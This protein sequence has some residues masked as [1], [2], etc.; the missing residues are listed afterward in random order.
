MIDW[1][2]TEE[3]RVCGKSTVPKDESNE[4]PFLHTVSPL[5]L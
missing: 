2:K 1:N 5:H 3:H 4:S